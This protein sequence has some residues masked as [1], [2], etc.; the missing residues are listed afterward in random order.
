M[1]P[2]FKTLPEVAGSTTHRWVGTA[3]MDFEEYD[4]CGWHQPKPGYWVARLEGLRRYG[5]LKR[6]REEAKWAERRARREAEDQWSAEV[7]RMQERTP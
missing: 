7:E 2:D 3:T 6:D 4:I 5:Q 1:T